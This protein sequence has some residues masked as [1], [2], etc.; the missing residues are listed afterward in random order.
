MDILQAIVLGLIQGITAWIPVS[1]KTQV[2]L[3]G[4]VLYGLSFKEL[5]SFAIA[6]HIGDLIASIYLFRAELLSI[7]KIRPDPVKDLKEYAKLDEPKKLAYFMAISLFCTAIVGLPVYLLLRKS[8]SDLQSNA[9]LAFIGAMLMVM[10]GIMFFSKAKSGE[11]KLGMR[12]TIMTG[13]AQGLAVLPGISRSGISESALLLQNIDQARAV[14]LSFIM[15]IPMIA[16]AIIGFQFT[17]GFGMLDLKTVVIGIIASTA[18]AYLTMSFM[19]ELAKRIKFYWF[20]LAMGLIALVP[21]LLQL[22]FNLHT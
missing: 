20:T 2:L 6:V 12:E 19:L 17:D 14:R 10:S 22:V 7:L 8:F 1:S 11:G 9:L 5:L 18:S 21:L 15:S 16:F 13:L 3:W 4:T